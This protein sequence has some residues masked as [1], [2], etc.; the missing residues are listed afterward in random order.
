MTFKIQKYQS[1][2]QTLSFRITTGNIL[3]FRISIFKIDTR[4]QHSA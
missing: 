1:L 2:H 3:F 4:F